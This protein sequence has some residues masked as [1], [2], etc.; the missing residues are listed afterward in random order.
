MTE[1]ERKPEERTITLKVTLPTKKTVIDAITSLFPGI[2]VVVE[3][4]KPAGSEEETE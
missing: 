1:E 4:E 2:E 3:E